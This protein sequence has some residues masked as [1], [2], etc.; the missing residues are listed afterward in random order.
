M[1]KLPPNVLDSAL[2]NR[3]LQYIYIYICLEIFFLTVTRMFLSVKV[4]DTKARYK[5]LLF[6]MDFVK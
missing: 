3:S 1:F 5:I 6:W 2:E 4:G